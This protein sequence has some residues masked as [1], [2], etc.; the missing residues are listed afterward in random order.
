MFGSISATGDLG[1]FAEV[2]KHFDLGDKMRVNLGAGGRFL[3]DPI[4]VIID[5]D[6]A[7]SIVEQLDSGTSVTISL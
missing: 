7:E 1:G 2:S 5:D 4:D 3:L 6:L